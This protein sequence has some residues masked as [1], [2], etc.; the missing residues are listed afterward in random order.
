[1]EYI[2]YHL[3]R[4]CLRRLGLSAFD[5]PEK[6]KQKPTEIR[7]LGKDDPIDSSDI[8]VALGEVIRKLAENT[9]A[10]NK[11]IKEERIWKKKGLLP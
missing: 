3:A 1:M 2:W 10:I 9:E 5:I 11:L 4:F 8:W 6:L 7:I